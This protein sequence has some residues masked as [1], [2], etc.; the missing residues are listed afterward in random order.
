MLVSRIAVTGIAPLIKRLFV[1]PGKGADLTDRPVRLSGYVSFKG[2]KR[3]LT[4]RDL[5]KLAS[6]LVSRCLRSMPPRERISEDQLDAVADTLARTLYALGDLDMDDVQAVQ[7][8]HKEMA[9]QLRHRNARQIS[10]LSVDAAGLHDAILEIASLHVLHFFSQR[11]SFISRTLIEQSRKLERITKI[12]DSLESQE[13]SNLPEDFKFDEQYLRYMAQKHARLTIYGIDLVETP[14]QWPLDT[15]YLTLHAE[16]TEIEEADPLL[17]ESGYT[18]VPLPSLPSDQVLTE[19]PRVMLRGVAGSGK[20]TLI[21]WLAVTAASQKLDPSLEYL[22]NR[23]PFVLPLRSITRKDKELPTPSGFLSAVGCPLSGIQPSGWAERTLAAGR[24]L[25]MVDGIDEIPENEREETRTWL[26]DL[27]SVF[28]GN[29]WLTTSRP[30]AVPDKWL[31]AERFTELALSPM[32]YSDVAAFIHRWHKAAGASESFGSSLLAAVRRKQ[33][34]SRLATN[35]LMCGLI[36]ALHR[37]RNAFLPDGRKELYDAALSMLYRRDRERNMG[38][39]DGIHLREEP[40]IQLLQKIAHWMIRNNR[41]EMDR[42]LAE[43]IISDALPSVASAASQGNSTQIFRHLLM[44]SGL[45]REPSPGRVDFIHRTFQDYLGA[46]RAIEVW[47]IGLLVANAGSSQWEDVIR[48]AVA[49]ARPNERAELISHIMEDGDKSFVPSTRARLYLLAMACLEHAV[50]LDPQVRKAVERRTAAL[51]PP[52]SAED[53]MALGEVGPMVL[54]F[55][56]HDPNDMAINY[57][58]AHYTVMTASMV[59]TDAAIPVLAAH[60]HSSKFP[61]RFQIVNSWRRFDTDRY[62]EEVISHLSDTDLF[63]PISSLQE[64]TTLRRLGGR[65]LLEVRGTFSPD[66]LIAN[67]DPARL[68]QLRLSKGSITSDLGWLNYFSNLRVLHLEDEDATIDVSSLA[69]MKK[70]RTVHAGCKQ[71]TGAGNLPLSITLR[72]Y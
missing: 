14:G 15:A 9:Q 55:L 44:R 39:P 64:L 71:V 20:T 72:I 10:E 32:G 63:F 67:I 53:V 30:S 8:G 47:D 33:D 41:A 29:L 23:I 36:C 56:P 16:P 24:A 4:E 21:Q 6:E 45:L 2:E 40:R 11:S 54:E 66:E 42:D 3:S 37:E 27:L 31:H 7:L 69:G 19:H 62:A 28:P 61:V 38:Q 17:F 13:A 51:L 52:Q 46:K 12:L 22:R 48:M 35:P 68:W 18:A 65:P 59:G 1:A 49:H 50:E 5:A 58:L 34:L 70:L 57:D 60:A 26:R 43:R 25:V